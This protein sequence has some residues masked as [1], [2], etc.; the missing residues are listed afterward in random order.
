MPNLPTWSVEV[1]LVVAGV[2]VAA[3]Y[4]A[5]VWLQRRHM[6]LTKLVVKAG[7][8]EGTLEAD[9]T[10]PAAPS[11]AAPT[12]SV[13]VSGN[14]MWRNNRIE[15]RQDDA[16]ASNNTMGSDNEIVIDDETQKRRS[17]KRK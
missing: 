2:L 5:R 10:S 11:P 13:N 6:K 17:Q 9:K 7:L 4:G 1:W 12:H 15:V 8:V 14:K 16:N 3:A